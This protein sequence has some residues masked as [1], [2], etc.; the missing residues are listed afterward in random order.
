[1]HSSESNLLQLAL[2]NNIGF[3]SSHFFEENDSTVCA[4]RLLATFVG[5]DTP[6]LL[7]KDEYVFYYM[8]LLFLLYRSPIVAPAA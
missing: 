7:S 6:R 5:A 2:Y 3:I 8:N 4:G 1:L